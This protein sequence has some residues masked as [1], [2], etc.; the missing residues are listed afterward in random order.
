MDSQY[1]F[2]TYLNLNFDRRRLALPSKVRESLGDQNQIVLTIIGDDKC[3]FGYSKNAWEQIIVR[4]ELSGSSINSDTGK[5][6]RR[7]MFS[8]AVIENL[9]DHGRFVVTQTLSQKAGIEKSAK[10]TVIGA[11]DHFEIWDPETWEKYKAKEKI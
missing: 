2:G 7:G 4:Q 3:V 10:V 1:F 8:N 9:D 6:L 11:G 5:Q